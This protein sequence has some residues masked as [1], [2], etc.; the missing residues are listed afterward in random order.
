MTKIEDINTS[1][2]RL[3]K[4]EKPRPI[5][6][7]DLQHKN[8]AV[9]KVRKSEVK[10]CEDLKQTKYIWLKNEQNLSQSQRL[11]LTNFLA[12]STLNTAIA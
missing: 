3:L 1:L 12:E 4:V 6:G 8:K 2:G 7:I 11:K 5:T 10:H 9:D